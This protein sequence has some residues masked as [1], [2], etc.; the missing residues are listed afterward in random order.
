[1][2]RVKRGNIRRKRHQKVLSRT[3][4]FRGS[5]SKLYRPAHQVMLHALSY[6]YKDR[7]R[8]KRDF[9]ALWIARISA[10]LKSTDLSYSK[11]I[12]LLKKKDIHLNRKMISEI[13]IQ[14]PG[15]LTHIIE[16]V[17]K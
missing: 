15:V 5:L 4:G 9:R 17:K 16:T 1:M 7:R 8:R 13:A 2:T 14:E 3:K 6:A 11:F 12:G 10:A